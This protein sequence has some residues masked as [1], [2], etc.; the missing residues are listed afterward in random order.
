MV[1][2]SIQLDASIPLQDAL[3]THLFLFTSRLLAISYFPFAVCC[4]CC[5]CYHVLLHTL[6][7]R[8]CFLAG[9]CLANCKT[10]QRILEIL[11]EQRNKQ[12]ARPTHAAAY[13]CSLG[14][15]CCCRAALSAAHVPAAGA[16]RQLAHSTKPSATGAPSD[17]GPVLGVPGWHPLLVLLHRARHLV[18]SMAHSC[19]HTG[20]Q[21][22]CHHEMWQGFKH[23]P[24]L[25]FE[26][27]PLVPPPTAPSQNKGCGESAGDEWVGQCDPAHWG[28]L[29]P[30][31]RSSDSP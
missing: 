2:T 20:L 8:L 19:T 21:K 24:S 15:C 3:D 1:A 16:A 29:R 10:T 5:P 9:I 4:P 30:C 28:S 27:L 22:A 7:D 17:V 23:R 12:T 31:R 18:A 25:P 11:H 6:E 14:C 26:L 13:Q